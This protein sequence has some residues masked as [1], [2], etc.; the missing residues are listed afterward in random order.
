MKKLI[1]CNIV[2]FIVFCLFSNELT[3]QS[4]FQICYYAIDNNIN[5]RLEPNTKSKVLGQ[6]FEDE[7]I[8][9]NLERSSKDWLF[10]YIPKINQVGYCSA[11]FFD[12]KPYFEDIIPS[13]IENDES[14]IKKIKQGHV[15]PS[16]IDTII[17]KQL[18]N[19]D[20]E[21]CLYI[22]SFVY[23]N[24][25]NKSSFNST[26]LIEAAKLNYSSVVKYLLEKKE[27]KEEINE[28]RNQF[29][30]PLYFALWKGNIEI[31]EMLLKN[32]ANP[33]NLTVYFD[34]MFDSI[35]FAVNN[36]AISYKKG[37]ELKDLLIKYGYNQ[38][39]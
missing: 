39:N 22:I 26:A 12:Y 1:L 13:L 7:E 24:G 17:S 20:E 18:M 10:C 2:F 19:K 16:F 15:I 31:A 28:K 21:T 33:N 4:D 6:L 37:A 25:C 11:K 38:N 23:E 32:G 34:T 27:F 29:A 5:I 36:D 14:V 30:Q 8:Y 9:V 3:D 35:D